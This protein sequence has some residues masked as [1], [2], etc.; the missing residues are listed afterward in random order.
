MGYPWLVV[1]PAIMLAALHLCSVAAAGSR[2]VA[3]VLASKT[4][5]VS[6]TLG[7]VVR[8]GQGAC[9]T[10]KQSMCFDVLQIIPPANLLSGSLVREHSGFGC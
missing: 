10:H 6:S 7:L 1:K 4:A 5:L 2:D 3:W 8:K 9:W